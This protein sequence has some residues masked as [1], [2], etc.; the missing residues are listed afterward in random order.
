MAGGG[1]AIGPVGVGGDDAGRARRLGG[2]LWPDAGLPF[3]HWPG[4]RAERSARGARCPWRSLSAQRWMTRRAGSVRS[5]RVCSARDRLAHAPAGHG[6]RGR[7]S[8]PG[9]A[10]LLA[11]A[12][13]SELTVDEA[14]TLRWLCG[15]EM[16]TLARFVW[17]VQR[18]HEAG[19]GRWRRERDR[20]PPDPVGGCRRGDV[21]ANHGTVTSVVHGPGTAAVPGPWLR[22]G[23]GETVIQV[24]PGLSL[25]TKS[26]RL[27]VIGRRMGGRLVNGPASRSTRERWTTRQGDRR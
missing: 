1:E 26:K 3:E 5:S 18:A 20:V 10:Q 22:P 25:K 13:V 16:A 27:V 8:V 14:G 12:G 23:R 17:M 11:E 4:G 7:G 24:G 9:G 6:R 15:W 21:Y 2:G 19:G